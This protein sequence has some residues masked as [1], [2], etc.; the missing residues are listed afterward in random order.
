MRGS[1]AGAARLFGCF[2]RGSEIL[3]GMNHLFLKHNCS[4]YKMGRF[5]FCDLNYFSRLG[6]QSNCFRIYKPGTESG[7]S[8]G[9]GSSI[10]T[11]RFASEHPENLRARGQTPAG[12]RCLT[13]RRERARGER[14]LTPASTSPRSRTSPAGLTARRRRRRRPGHRQRGK[15]PQRLLKR[16]WASLIPRTQLMDEM[17]PRVGGKQRTR[18]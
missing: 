10:V 13:R 1:S 6:R 15:C 4:F 2:A 9:H 16:L 3:S 8:P 18:L 17:S 12:G 14:T 11:G 7:P 5:C